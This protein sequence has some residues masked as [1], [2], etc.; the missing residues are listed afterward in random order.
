M[1]T[2]IIFFLALIF[3][4]CECLSSGIEGP[5]I[6]L[7]VHN[8]VSFGWNFTSLKNVN[9]DGKDY[10]SSRVIQLQGVNSFGVSVST[11]LY[12]CSDIRM[13]EQINKVIFKNYITLGIDFTVTR[14]NKSVY[15]DSLEAINNT[16]ISKSPVNFLTDGNIN[17]LGF[18]IGK[19]LFITNYLLL[20]GSLSY[21]AQWGN[22][23][24]K[25]SLTDKEVLFKNDSNFTFSE[26]KKE[27]ILSSQNIKKGIL[28]LELSLKYNFYFY[29]HNENDINNERVEALKN[30][31]LDGG[32]GKY[33]VARYLAIYKNIRSLS[34]EGGFLYQINQFDNFK[35]YSFGLKLGY[36]F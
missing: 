11:G 27:I 32:N 19:S 35:P 24:Q 17:K 8:S 13:I 28:E 3:L 26:D 18:N 34:L 1:K 29:T 20:N 30:E 2:N 9:I 6:G 5:Q 7:I 12:S 33:D 4:K 25:L 16:G 23:K 10:F 22:L 31:E 15:Y 21:N 36:N 14:I